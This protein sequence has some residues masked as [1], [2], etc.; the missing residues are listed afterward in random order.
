MDR[1]TIGTICAT[2]FA[3]GI[4][5]LIGVTAVPAESAYFSILLWGGVAAIAVGF[6][7]LVGLA[8]WPRKERRVASDDR[9]KSAGHYFE[10]CTDM[11]V[12]NCVGIGDNPFVDIGGTKNTF[13]GN[14]A[15]VPEREKPK[16]KPE[17]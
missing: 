13:R 7:G 16:P 10:D 17:K 2:I 11:M 5:S 4:A 9:P 12:E 1:R 6:T 3:G 14:L 8:I 15:I